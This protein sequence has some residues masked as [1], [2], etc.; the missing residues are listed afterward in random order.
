MDKS[1]VNGKDANAVFQWLKEE[2]KGFLGMK[3]IKWNF[4][5]FLIDQS[6]NVVNRYSSLQKPETISK[7]VAD[8]LKKGGAAPVSNGNG[9]VAA[10][11]KPAAPE[12]VA[13]PSTEAPVVTQA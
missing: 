11:E 12:A 13:A 7:D 10:T 6:G 1:D 3:K 4:E 8:L 5:K 2:K 9:A